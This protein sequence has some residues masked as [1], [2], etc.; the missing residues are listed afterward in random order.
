M[1]LLKQR[2][3]DLNKSFLKCSFDA[4][5]QVL[6]YRDVHRKLALISHFSCNKCLVFSGP[7]SVWE[8]VSL[9][10]AALCGL[11]C[12]PRWA[13]EVQELE[14]VTAGRPSLAAEMRCVM[15]EEEE[16]AGGSLLSLSPVCENL[17]VVRFQR[18]TPSASSA[19]VSHSSLSAAAA[20]P[21][22]CRYSH[23]LQS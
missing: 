5:L 8:H 7:S 4:H 9:I 3:V 1:L 13:W 17:E 2:D 11:M 10:A 20:A 18:G 14:F 21:Q 15:R 16:E 12:R 22:L 23:F 19:A 6:S